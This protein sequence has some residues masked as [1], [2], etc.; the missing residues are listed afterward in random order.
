MMLRKGRAAEPSFLYAL[1]FKNKAIYR[2]KV[3]LIDYCGFMWV[4]QGL[5]G[6]DAAAY[7]KVFKK[8]DT[9]GEFFCVNMISE[10]IVKVFPLGKIKALFL[11][12]SRFR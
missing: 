4:Y 8:C 10:K 1:N 12:K 6:S 9:Q 11:P 7:K 3:L 5:C 2:F